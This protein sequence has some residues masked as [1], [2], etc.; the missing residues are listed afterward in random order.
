MLPH[1]F[2]LFSEA[3][4]VSIQDTIIRQ[5]VGNIF[6]CSKNEICFFDVHVSF[7]RSKLASILELLKYPA[8]EM[9]V[10]ETLLF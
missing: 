9:D 7:V 2:L 4:S 8:S 10:F 6:A 3:D 1:E 5:K